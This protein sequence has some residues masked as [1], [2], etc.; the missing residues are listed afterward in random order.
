[1]AQKGWEK[2]GAAQEAESRSFRREDSR[3]AIGIVL[4]VLL[5]FIL[6]AMLWILGADHVFVE[7]FDFADRPNLKRGIEFIGFVALTGL[8]LSLALWSVTKDMI[9]AKRKLRDSERE[10]VR[11][12]G[13]AAEWRDDETGDHTARVGEYCAAIAGSFGWKREQCEEIRVAAMLHDIGKIGIPDFVMV[14]E[15]ALSQEERQLI[16]A[17]T[18]MG[19]DILADSDVPLLQMAQ[20]IAMSHHERWDGSGYPYG[21]VGTEIPIEGRIAA[22]ADVFDA[23]T[24]RRRY[25]GAWTFD[26]AVNEIKELGDKQ[27][28]PDVVSAFIAALPALKVI[29]DKFQ[30]T[31]RSFNVSRAA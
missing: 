24:S 2:L 1:M 16:Q 8:L 7:V 5:V 18:L 17:H 13:Q 25:K 30:G 27:F 23:L 19:S 22:L 31:A 28:D 4:R 29:Y 14:K 11:R 21:L 26:Q 10:L 3:A 20:K 12:L 6:F 9:A 15:G